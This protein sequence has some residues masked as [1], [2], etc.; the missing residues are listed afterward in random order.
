MRL[1]SE[2]FKSI[3][4]DSKKWDTSIKRYFLHNYF[5]ISQMNIWADHMIGGCNITH[6]WKYFQNCSKGG[7]VYSVFPCWSFIEIMK[8]ALQSLPILRGKYCGKRFA[9]LS[10]FSQFEL[11]RT[12]I[13]FM[14]ISQQVWKTLPVLTSEWPMVSFNFL[15]GY[16]FNIC[17][18]QARGRPVGCLEP[19]WNWSK[20]G[21]Q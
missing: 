20:P 8:F 17:K 18:Y 3:F 5:S 9:Q 2:S 13:A 1:I 11:S 15:V 6:I 10:P 14:M 16:M 4:W 21:I 7:K 19:K 12:Q